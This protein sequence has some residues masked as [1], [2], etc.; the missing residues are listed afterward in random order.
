[1]PPHRE[2]NAASDG[3]PPREVRRIHSADIEAELGRGKP[4]RVMGHIGFFMY[5][6]QN[7]DKAA[8]L[9][10]VGGPVMA[11]LR[12]ALVLRLAA[13]GDELQFSAPAP[14]LL[15]SCWKVKFT[16]SLP[17]EYLSQVQTWGQASANLVNLGKVMVGGVPYPT[18]IVLALEGPQRKEFL[19]RGTPV[20][21]QPFARESFLRRV[22]GLNPSDI[23][24]VSD[25]VAHGQVSAS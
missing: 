4:F 13:S 24:E 17:V 12:E 3:T 14:W 10:V 5:F 20:E 2:R 23:T 1:M 25:F 21:L 8:I 9:R 16:L 6:N 15:A 22:Y 19:V 11:A 18:D 7:T